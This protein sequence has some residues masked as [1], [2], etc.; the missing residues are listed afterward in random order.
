[1]FCAKLLKG[2]ETNRTD[3]PLFPYSKETNTIAALS[4]ES[5]QFMAKCQKPRSLLAG[6]ALL[7]VP[8]VDYQVGSFPCPKEDLTMSQK[9]GLCDINVK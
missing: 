4:Q 2:W 8:Q 6:Q 7:R 1:M 5:S 9:V 3:T